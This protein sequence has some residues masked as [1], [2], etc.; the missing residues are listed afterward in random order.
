M[1]RITLSHTQ[2]FPPNTMTLPELLDIAK[3][4]NP[5]LFEH[6]W[7]SPYPNGSQY[8]VNFRLVHL[9]RELRLPQISSEFDVNSKRSED[10]GV[11][12]SALS[13]IIHEHSRVTGLRV[14]VSADGTEISVLVQAYAD[15][16][17]PEFVITA[18]K[19]ILRLAMRATADYMSDVLGIVNKTI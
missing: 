7:C 17:I 14:I 11:E 15:D 1:G 6:I 13:S 19:R 9:F 5:K 16:T 8:H 3:R 18:A 10:G 12:Y 2:T 4:A